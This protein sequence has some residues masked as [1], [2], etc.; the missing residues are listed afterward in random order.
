[1]LND[2]AKVEKLAEMSWRSALNPEILA[3]LMLSP[4]RMSL[5]HLSA[6]TR[7]LADNRQQTNRYDIA[8]WKKI[9]YPLAGLVMVALA[10]PFSAGHHRASGIGLQIFA[11][12]MIGVLF[13]TLNG[14][15]SNLGAIHGWSPL[16][17]AA[18]PSAL[19]LLAAGLMIW[20]V[21]RR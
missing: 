6:Y 5:R 1:M 17:S 16:L 3:V 20:W 14:L 8:F 12:V 2:S 19:F 15:S 13:H 9:V 10:L 4:D 7:H 21:E 18:A 11:G